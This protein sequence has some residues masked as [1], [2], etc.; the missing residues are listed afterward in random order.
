MDDEPDPSVGPSGAGPAVGRTEP[1][2]RPSA[3]T[4]TAA[5]G[6]LAALATAAVDS[7]AVTRQGEQEPVR[8]WSAGADVLVDA[9]AVA[10][11]RLGRD[12]RC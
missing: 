7:R 2:P 11:P 6:P 10:A 5:V 9:G 4:P 1:T 8:S 3:P 12:R